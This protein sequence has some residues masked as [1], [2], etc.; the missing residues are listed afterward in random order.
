MLEL[1]TVESFEIK[2]RGTAYAVTVPLGE[3]PPEWSG[4]VVLLD[5]QRVRIVGV[6]LFPTCPPS[7]SPVTPIL[8]R[9]EP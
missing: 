5:G 7:W 4:Q 2:G 1:T 3:R 6:E 9:P 8:V